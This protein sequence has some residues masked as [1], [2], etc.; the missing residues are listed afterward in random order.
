M[1]RSPTHAQIRHARKPA[2]LGRPPRADRTQVR[3]RIN[4]TLP[5]DVADYLTE[6]GGG[7]RSQAIVALAR[8]SAIRRDPAPP[9]DPSG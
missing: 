1:T 8:A 9:R 5:R 3:A 7:N 4:V 6:L 2:R